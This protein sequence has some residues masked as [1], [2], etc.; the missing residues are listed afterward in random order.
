MHVNT[1]MYTHMHTHIRYSKSA[2]AHMDAH[3]VLA[4]ERQPTHRKVL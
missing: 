4:S 3:L 1:H 2:L